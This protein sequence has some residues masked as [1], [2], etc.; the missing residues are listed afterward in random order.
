MFFVENNDQGTKAR[1]GLLKT[2]HGDIQTPFFMPVGTKA[3]VKALSH[4]DLIRT[5]A[6]IILSNTYHLFLRPGMDIIKNAGGLHRFMSWNKPILTDSGGYQVFSLSQFRKITNEGVKFQSYIDGTT[7]FLTPEDVISI[8]GILGSDIMMPLDECSPYPCTEKQAK[9][10]V[11]RTTLW[12]KRSREYFLSSPLKEKHLLFGI[13]QGS[14]YKHYREQSAKDIIDIGFDGYAIGGVSVGE[15]VEFIFQAVD[16]VVPFL[17]KEKPRYVM[18]IGMPDQIVKAVGQGIDMFDT[19]IPTR[20]GRNGSAFTSKGRL[21]VRNGAYSSD[22]RP[23]DENCD[24]FVCQTYSRSYIRHLYN[25]NEITG[26]YLISY[27]NMH[28]YINMMRNIR[29]AIRDNRY[30]DFQKEFLSCYGSTL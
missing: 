30:Q 21:I 6:Q 24:C 19:C 10:A 4:E 3:T 16:Q 18:G 25:M 28:F 7:H 9:K 8:Q 13:V 15:P 11:E 1:N 17:P 12:A 22:L 26:L 14:N 23:L 2:G 29:Q 27:H 20:Y 5:G